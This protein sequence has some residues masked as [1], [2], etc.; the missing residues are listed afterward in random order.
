[1]EPLEFTQIPWAQGVGLFF[2]FTRL[3]KIELQILPV[4][5]IQLIEASGFNEYLQVSTALGHFQYL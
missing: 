1:M 3:D 4:V 5:K 2:R